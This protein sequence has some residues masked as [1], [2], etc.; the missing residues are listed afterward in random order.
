MTSEKVFAFIISLGFVIVA[1]ILYMDQAEEDA[2]TIK[3]A[4]NHIHQLSTSFSTLHKIDLTYLNHFDSQVLEARYR[5]RNIIEGH[6][7]Q[8]NSISLPTS[9][10]QHVLNLE[11]MLK[12]YTAAFEEL[13]ELQTNL[14]TNPQHGQ[15]GILRKA[16]HNIEHILSQHKQEQLLNLL[17]NL[18][19]AE[20]D[21]MLHPSKEKQRQF[22]TLF[23]QFDTL[24]QPGD[25]PLTAQEKLDLAK[26]DYSH[27][28][29]Y[30][31]NNIIRRGQ[32]FSDGLF[33]KLNK[34]A[35]KIESVIN[36]LM[37]EIIRLSHDTEQT[38]QGKAK[39]LSIILP[40]CVLVFTLIAFVAVF[41]RRPR[42]I[43]T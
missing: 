32:L 43:S 21:F 25:L 23:Q 34:E 40:T 28:F 6:I 33:G 39:M 3:S 2:V 26:K 7:S 14:G 35:N 10:S 12:S 29:N 9:L 13:V 15:H 4:M 17:L 22:A 8:L 27:H 5:Y 24:T 38:V 31:A 19:R 41:F 42:E 30:Y 36:Y 1:C 16:A 18:R 37:S 20:K 11:P